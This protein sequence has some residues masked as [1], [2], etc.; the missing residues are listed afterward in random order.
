MLTISKV[1]LFGHRF[2][3]RA[4]DVEKALERVLVEMG[5]LTVLLHQQYIE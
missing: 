1:V 3:D 5:T 2:V 4:I